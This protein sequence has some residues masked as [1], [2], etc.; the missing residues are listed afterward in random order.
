MNFLNGTEVN[1]QKKEEMEARHGEEG[2][3]ELK[4]EEIREY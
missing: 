1:V 3:K 4:E 2:Q